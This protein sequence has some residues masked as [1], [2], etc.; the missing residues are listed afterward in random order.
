M[1]SLGFWKKRIHKFIDYP[2]A[3]WPFIQKY[4]Y[5]NFV[6]DRYIKQYEDIK[7]LNYKETID[8][9]ISNDKSI[10]RFGDELIDMFK[11][12][13]LYYDDWHQKYDPKLVARLKE[14]LSFDN[15]KLMVALH[16]QFF[17][18][19]KAQLKS[20]GIPPHIWTNAKVFMRQY[21][22]SN[23]VYGSALCFQ[24]KYNPDIDFEKI[25]KYLKTKHVI[26][27]TGNIKRFEHIKLG[28]TTDFVGCPK[29]DSWFHYEDIFSKAISIPKNKGY[30]KEDVL[31]L[32]SLASAAKVFVLDLLKFG[33]QGW[34]TGQ[35]FDLAF[36]EIEKVSKE[37]S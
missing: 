5:Y 30:R 26:I 9:I 8:D 24:P 16:W 20:E 21:M 23:R 19:T 18:K 34:D 35:F 15:P 28:K 7:F 17:T 6:S 22:H 32:V 3:I 27:I 25:G 33:Y 4:C 36:K 10:V 31:F 12:I 1:P 13:G 11:G 29:N 14:V 37:N 2:P